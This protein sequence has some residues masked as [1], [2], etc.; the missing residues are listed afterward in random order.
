MTEKQL[1]ERSYEILKGKSKWDL[2][3][4][5]V[6]IGG[7]IADGLIFLNG[8]RDPKG[9][10]IIGLE[11]KTDADTFDRV[12]AQTNA[13]LNICD[14]V[15]L[16]V[17]NKDPPKNLPFYVGII[18][19][20]GSNTLIMRR[21]QNLKHST[22]TIELWSSLMNNVKGRCK[23][24]RELNMYKLFKEIEDLKRKLIWSQ[25]VDGWP[26]GAYSFKLTSRE[27]SLIK[28]FAE[29]KNN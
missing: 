24:H 18:K 7:R 14:E 19:I 13:Y 5:Q 26:S 17:Q 8:E 2:F 16:V 11:V 9:S 12:Y 25:F 21:A 28:R 20:L 15:Y 23:I 3:R 6:E 27:K 22:D 1:L 29:D 4:S 10:K